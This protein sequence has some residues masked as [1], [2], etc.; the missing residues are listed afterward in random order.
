MNSKRKIV[1][2][3]PSLVIVY[4]AFASDRTAVYSVNAEAMTEERVNIFTWAQR[5]YKNYHLYAECIFGRDFPQRVYSLGELYGPDKEVA[6]EIRRLRFLKKDFR[7]VTPEKQDGFP[8]FE[9]LTYKNV[10]IFRS[11]NTE[12]K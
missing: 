9:T 3:E 10:F 1:N 12:E 6:E 5:E 4:Y 11:W 7:E 8:L 2:G